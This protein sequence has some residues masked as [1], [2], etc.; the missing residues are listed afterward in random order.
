MATP[1][2]GIGSFASLYYSI[3]ETNCSSSPLSIAQAN[4]YD[5]KLCSQ[6]QISKFVKRIVLNPTEPTLLDCFNQINFKDWKKEEMV[7]FLIRFQGHLPYPLNCVKT[8][9]T[10]PNLPEE[11]NSNQIPLAPN[12]NIPNE[13][14][15]RTASASANASLSTEMQERLERLGRDSQLGKLSLDHLN[16]TEITQIFIYLEHRGWIEQLTRL[17]IQKNIKKIE[18]QALAKLHPKQIFI[19][20]INSL[21]QIQLLELEAVKFLPAQLKQLKVSNFSPSTILDKTSEQVFSDFF[22]SAGIDLSQ[23]LQDL[24]ATRENMQIVAELLSVEWFKFLSIEQLRVIDF[25][26]IDINKRLHIPSEIASKMANYNT[27]S[28]SSASSH[29]TSEKQPEMMPT[30]IQEIESFIK[31]G[32]LS[33][34]RLEAYLPHQIA[35]ICSFLTAEQMQKLTVATICH[36]INKINASDIDK[37][38]TNLPLLQR[39]HIDLNVLSLPQLLRFKSKDFRREQLVQFNMSVFNCIDS[40][41]GFYKD[42]DTIDSASVAIIPPAYINRVAQF[43]P[44][45]WF[46]IFSLLNKETLKKIDLNQLGEN[47]REIP[48]RILAEMQEKSHAHTHYSHSSHHRTHYSS[49]SSVGLTTTESAYEKSLK[50]AQAAAKNRAYTKPDSPYYNSLR[51]IIAEKSLSF[52]PK[53]FYIYYANSI[54]G[55]KLNREHFFTNKKSLKKLYTGIVLELH[56][57]KNGDD[58]DFSNAIWKAFKE[59]H[60]FFMQQA[61]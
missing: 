2:N 32:R 40:F 49:S 1:S 16:S 38:F 61:R 8:T 5:L 43:I 17:T 29:A 44:G 47:K 3:P 50:E 22:K 18:S 10:T 30:F 35:A 14:I 51:S 46:T 33:Y 39:H 27:H 53:D 15:I 6:E 24:N 57:D 28:T 58:F 9:T 25:S 23:L 59:I 52:N 13:S 48:S 56:P 36:N 12:G 54:P 55:M 37:W 41:V 31:A 11:A 7:L 20:N 26:Q 19:L 4:E 45:K 60:N 42:G 34:L 21:S